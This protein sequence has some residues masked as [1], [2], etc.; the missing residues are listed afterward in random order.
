MFLHQFKWFNND[1]EIGS[2]PLNWNYLV[3]EKETIAEVPNL[4]HYTL[5]GPYFTDYRDVDYAEL[6]NSYYKEMKNINFK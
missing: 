2:I 3:G 4:I 5:G 6:W 1:C